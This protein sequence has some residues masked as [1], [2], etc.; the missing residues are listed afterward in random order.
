MQCK[1]FLKF[2]RCLCLHPVCLTLKMKALCLFKTLGIA[3]PVTQYH[4]DEDLIH[5]EYHC[6][7]LKSCCGVLYFD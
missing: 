2:Q 4:I 5:E 1:W 3:H 6:E 7:N